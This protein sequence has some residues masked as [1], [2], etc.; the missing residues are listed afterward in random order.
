MFHRLFYH[1]RSRTE[2]RGRE[3]RPEIRMTRSKAKEKSESKQ[4][5]VTKNTHEISAHL[6]LSTV[7]SEPEKFPARNVAEGPRGSLMLAFFEHMG[8]AH[9]NP[10][11]RFSWV[12]ACA[13]LILLIRDFPFPRTSGAL[14]PGLI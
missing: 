13:K 9:E 2:D 1:A 14:E 12:V 5:M 8:A 10:R 6:C 7:T 3:Y 4:R 11:L